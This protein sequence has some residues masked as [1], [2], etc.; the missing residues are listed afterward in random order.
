MRARP[1]PAAL[2]RLDARFQVVEHLE[3]HV[4]VGG[5][6]LHGLG[7]ALRVH[8]H[9]VEARLRRH[10]QAGRIVAQRR[11]VVEDLGAGFRGGLRHGRFAGVDGDDGLKP[12]E[13]FE[14]RHHAGKLLVVLDRV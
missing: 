5:I 3:H 6:V 8:E 9:H 4:V 10:V 11:H 12:V 7:L 14:H 1:M 2:A 13:P